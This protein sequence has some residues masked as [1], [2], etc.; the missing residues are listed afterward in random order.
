MENKRLKLMS[1]IKKKYKLIDDRNKILES[2]WKR[3]FYLKKI[4]II[5]KQ[6]DDID[7]KIYLFEKSHITKEELDYII[8]I[9]NM[10][11]MDHCYTED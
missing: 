7:K 6:I 11:L 5:D 3:I 8:L 9:S 4:K 10:R 2:F 1:L